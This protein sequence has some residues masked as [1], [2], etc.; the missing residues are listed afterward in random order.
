MGS[1]R[2]ARPERIRGEARSIAGMVIMMSP[3]L[4]SRRIF[5]AA[6]KACTF[7]LMSVVAGRS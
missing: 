7:G 3:T 4:V 2:R 1:N 5:A 6:A